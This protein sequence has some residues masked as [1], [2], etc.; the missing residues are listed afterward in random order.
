MNI[1]ITL[2]PLSV[3]HL[4]VVRF[5][6]L[7]QPESTFWSVIA[8]RLGQMEGDEDRAYLAASIDANIARSLKN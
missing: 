6:P 4:Q 7:E 3:F 8:A 1:R 2:I 5:S